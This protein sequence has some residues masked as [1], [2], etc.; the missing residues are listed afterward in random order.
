MSGTRDPAAEG[1][2]TPSVL[3][4]LTFRTGWERS[5]CFVSTYYMLGISPTWFSCSHPAKVGFVG[6]FS[7]YQHVRLRE[8]KS[9]TQAH[10]P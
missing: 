3:S 7:R 9:V 4:E 10:R 6:P 2:D 1:M 8:V 5:Q